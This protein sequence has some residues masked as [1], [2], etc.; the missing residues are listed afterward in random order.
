MGDGWGEYLAGFHEERAGITEAVLSRSRHGGADPYRWLIQAVP[1]RGRVLDLACGSAPLWPYL[2]GRDYLGIDRAPGELAAAAARGAG[3]LVRASATV[4]PVRSGS[5]AVVTCSMALM[6]LTPLPA[7][8]AEIARVLAPGGRLIATVPANRPLRTA[9]LPA[10]AGLL[11]A[12]G[13]RLTYPNDAPLRRLPELL[14]DAG[15]RLVGDEHRRFGYP[16]SGGDDADRFL[17]SLY[18]PGLPP[19]RLRPARAWLRTLARARTTLPVPIRRC[20]AVR[21]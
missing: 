3:P 6:L 10:V 12:L 20:V 1:A 7:A 17:A 11:L 9:D 4:L 5:V 15:L 14:G 21:G 19:A 18:L 13:R 16:L 2:A 8:L